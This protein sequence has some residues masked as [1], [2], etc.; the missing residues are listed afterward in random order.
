MVTLPVR[1]TR[2]GAQVHKAR[3]TFWSLVLVGINLLATSLITSALINENIFPW[4]DSKVSEDE[5][6]TNWLT[7][8]F[9]DES[10]E[11]YVYTHRY[12]FAG[13]RYT[14]PSDK[15]TK[16]RF[17]FAFGLPSLLSHLAGSL[18][19]LL[20][21]KLVHPWRHLGREREVN[22]VGKL[23]GTKRGLDEEMSHW[24]SS[25]AVSFY[26]QP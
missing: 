25:D 14:F 17:L 21:Y 23:G 4:S 15:Y 5:L 8:L 13:K 12:T 26:E 20:Q 24:R 16:P 18:L 19:L 9:L 2:E 6:E 10:V 22:F 11:M 3:E 7:R 1:K